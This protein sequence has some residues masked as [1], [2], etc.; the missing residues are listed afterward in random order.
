VIHNA[1]ESINLVEVLRDELAGD[2]IGRIASG[3]GAPV[4][5]V[6]L[7]ADRLAVVMVAVLAK[8]AA[9]SQGL[10]EL[11]DLM[12]TTGFD[13]SRSQPLLG[14]PNAVS[15]L[16]DLVARGL[17]M[18]ARLLGTRRPTVVDWIASVAALDRQRASTLLALLAPLALHVVGRQAR[19]SG[20]LS[21]PVLADLLRSQIGLLRGMA[22]DGLA[23]AFG[24]I[25]LSGAVVTGVPATGTPTTA[26]RRWLR[27]SALISPWQRFS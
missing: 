26:P 19:R 18:G 23:A 7:A 16:I 5:N 3:I 9:T 27:W 11:I 24:W 17:P 21:G 12:H 8:A 4:P 25:D 10:D 2:A 22:P 1:V 13:G 6:S 14:R 15:S 20:R